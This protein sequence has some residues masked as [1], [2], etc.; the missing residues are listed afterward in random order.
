MTNIEKYLGFAIKSGEIIRGQDKI[1]TTKDRFYVLILCRS[2]SA[3]L[4]NLARN[5]ATKRGIKLIMVD[6]LFSLS[7]IENCKILAVANLS[8]AKEILKQTEEYNVI[9][10]GE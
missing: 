3:N 8:L 1:K 9:T 10:I 6:D 5:V 2:A 4:V 7:H